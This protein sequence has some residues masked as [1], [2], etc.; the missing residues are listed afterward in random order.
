M[1]KHFI[2]SIFSVLCIALQLSAAPL[3]ETQSTTV[4][5]GSVSDKITKETLAGAV[6]TANG[7]KVYTD[8]DGNFTISNV[9]EG[10][11]KVKINYISYVEQNIDVDLNSTKSIEVKLQSR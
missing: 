3:V 2:L 5:R 4:L 6:V 8:L 10:H 7:Q 1:K 11:C 9:C